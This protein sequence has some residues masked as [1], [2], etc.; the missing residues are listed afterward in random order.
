MQERK[1]IQNVK[2][3]RVRGI[4]FTKFSKIPIFLINYANR[5]ITITRHRTM[6]SR[7]L[8]ITHY[9]HVKNPYLYIIYSVI[10]LF[11]INHIITQKIIFSFI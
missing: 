6:F 3:M 5:M 10:I 2:K 1:K 9:I 4:K 11:F 7:G 8:I